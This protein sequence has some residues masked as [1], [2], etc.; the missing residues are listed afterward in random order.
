MPTRGRGL[1]ATVTK[2]NATMHYKTMVLEMIQSEYPALHDRL[3]A[4]RSLLSAVED[5]A[6]ALRTAHRAW[7]QEYR[8][9][10]PGYDPAR[11]SSMALEPATE[12]LREALRSASTP[13]EDDGEGA[14]LEEAMAFLLRHPATPSA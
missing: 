3:R 6:I 13:S 11:L 14:G 7:E 4:S 8:Q 5:Y 9:A 12:Q 1:Q 2:G 10:N